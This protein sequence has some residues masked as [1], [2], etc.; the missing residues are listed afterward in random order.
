MIRTWESPPKQ[1]MNQL[2]TEEIERL[3]HKRAGAKLGWYFHFVVYVL[4]NSALFAMSYFGLR[5]RPW[6]MY[7]VLGWGLGLALHGASVFL[8][9]QGSGVREKM[10]QAERERLQR[11][12]NGGQ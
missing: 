8:L 4:V 7:P 11:Q 3:A 6:S 1:S 10:V 12:Q 9:G 2:S 5:D